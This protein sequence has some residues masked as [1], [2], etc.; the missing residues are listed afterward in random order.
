[1]NS[2]IGHFVFCENEWFFGVQ[3][4]GKINQSIAFNSREQQGYH[5]SK[6]SR[7]FKSM[8]TSYNYNNYQS[9][10]LRWYAAANKQ[11][12]TRQPIIM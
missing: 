6:Q 10:L 1:M 9:Y 4:N 2:R 12:G 8:Q 5:Y 11:A 7:H 3:S